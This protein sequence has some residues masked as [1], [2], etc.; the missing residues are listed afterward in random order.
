M[1]CGDSRSQDPKLQERLGLL[2]AANEGKLDGLPCPSCKAPAVSVWFTGPAENEY[3]TWFICD[4]CG[5]EMRA[6]NTERPAHYSEDRDLGRRDSA[7]DP[8][9]IAAEHRS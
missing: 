3:R 7:R 6:Q 4:R 9:L 2:Q 8:G 5:F 1:L